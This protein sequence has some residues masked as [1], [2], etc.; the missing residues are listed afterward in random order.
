MVQPAFSFNIRQKWVD[1]NIKKERERERMLHNVLFLGVKI[2][3]GKES[4]VSYVN[5]I[6]KESKS[7]TFV[8]HIPIS[9]LNH[10]TVLHGLLLH[11]LKLTLNLENLPPPATH[12]KLFPPHTG[13]QGMASTLYFTL[14]AR[15]STHFMKGEYWHDG[16]LSS[17]TANAATGKVIFFFLITGDLLYSIFGIISS[18]TY[19]FFSTLS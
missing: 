1:Q 17:L 3:I 12:T 7:N 14:T 15:L 10:I 16:G 11:R 19:V 18:E 9:P 2:L 4:W 6:L 13:L 8:S 5:M